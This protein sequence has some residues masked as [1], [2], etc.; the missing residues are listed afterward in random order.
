LERSERYLLRE[1]WVLNVDEDGLLRI[2]EGL[3]QDPFAGLLGMKLLEARPGYSRVSMV[4]RDDMM[5]FQG[6]P[7]GGAVFSLADAAFGAAAN[8]H[9]LKSVGLTMEICYL[10]TVDCGA[11]LIAEAT[12]EHLGERTALYHITVVTDAG[13]LVAS[14][15]GVVYRKKERFPD[16]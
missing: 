3:R 16:S 6:T 8:A 7:H 12:E 2:V 5:N 15:H 4:L 13:D 1:R 11:T 10:K 14:C 9:G